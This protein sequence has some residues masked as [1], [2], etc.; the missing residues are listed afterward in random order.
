MTPKLHKPPEVWDLV[1][2]LD[3]SISS[4]MAITVCCYYSDYLQQPLLA[5]LNPSTSPTPLPP[6]PDL[7]ICYSSFYF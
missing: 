1:Y 4:L 3:F 6:I 2:F 5:T 7:F